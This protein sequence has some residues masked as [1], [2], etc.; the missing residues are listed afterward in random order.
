MAFKVRADI[1]NLRSSIAITKNNTTEY[2]KTDEEKKM[3]QL[4]CDELDY[5]VK[6]ILDKFNQILGGNAGG[7][8][9]LKE[10]IVSESKSLA[11]SRVSLGSLLDMQNDMKRSQVSSS[12]S[13]RNLQR[14]EAP[15]LNSVV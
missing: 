9:S 13:E 7:S 10:S 14:V 12:S 2:K 1:I 5:Y 11:M 15:K 6:G 3:F 8:S 4:V